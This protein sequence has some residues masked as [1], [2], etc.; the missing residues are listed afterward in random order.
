MVRRIAVVFVLAVLVLVPATGAVAAPPGGTTLDVRIGASQV[1]L[2]ADG[3]VS[4]PLRARCSAPLDA[5]EVDVGVTQGGAFGAVSLIGT[6][7]P[8]CNGHWQRTTLIVSPQAGAFGPG[9]ASVEV[10]LGAYDPVDDSDLDAG[11]TATV[12]L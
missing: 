9:R 10:F 7:Y 2:N 8:V 5:F 1:A 6:P 12:R 3:T 11:D 4:V